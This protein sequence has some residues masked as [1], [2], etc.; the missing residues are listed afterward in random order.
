MGMTDYMKFYVLENHFIEDSIKESPEFAK[1][2]SETDRDIKLTQIKASVNGNKQPWSNIKYL[3]L[4]KDKM[5]VNGTDENSHLIKGVDFLISTITG[6]GNAYNANVTNIRNVDDKRIEFSD[7]GSSADAVCELFN[8]ELPK[9]GDRYIEVTE[10]MKDAEFGDVRKSDFYKYDEETKEYKH[11]YQAYYPEGDINGQCS[12]ED[13]IRVTKAIQKRDNGQ[14]QN[15][16]IKAKDK[17][18]P[19]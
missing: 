15:L 7:G 16:N 9:V 6:K 4:I 1:A 11:W 14:K 12:S 10:Q 17:S 8:G 19:R 18:N 5:L 2:V 3:N 13:V